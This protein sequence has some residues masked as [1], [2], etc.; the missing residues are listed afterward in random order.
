[1]HT[2]VLFLIFNRPDTTIRVFESIRQ[3]KP[4]RLYVAADGPRKDKVGEKEKCEE[5]R[6]I[7]KQVDWDC[8]VKTLF[9]DENFGCGKAVSQ[10][11]S[12]FFEQEEEG[13]IL[14]DDVLPHP[15]FFLY[16]EELLERYRNVEQIKLIG[17]RNHLYKNESEKDSY[18]YYFSSINHIWGWASWRRVWTLYNFDLTNVPYRAFSKA[19]SNIYIDKNVVRFWKYHYFLMKYH[20]INTWDYQLDIVL[21]YN[22]SY[23]IVPN[24]NIVKNI[25]F[26][27]D[28]THTVVGDTLKTQCESHPI[29]P[30]NHPQVIVL[31]SDK[32]KIELENERRSIS[33]SRYLYMLI[34]LFAKYYYA[35]IVKKCIHCSK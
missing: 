4:P 14:E 9:R 17:G 26:G 8:K 32:D 23:S 16:C 34:R 13:I 19:L 1:M 18:S 33:L 35:V 6:S 5:V 24:V 11:I 30:L 10:A 3:A 29:L 15:D 12:W 31:A 7:I 28:A 2:A 25:G 27:S 22:K 20:M 21:L